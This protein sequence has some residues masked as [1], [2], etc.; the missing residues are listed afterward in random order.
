MEQVARLANI[1]TNFSIDDW[2]DFTTPV[3]A[4][5]TKEFIKLIEKI[6]DNC[7][8][9]SSCMQNPALTKEDKLAYTNAYNAKKGQLDQICDD[10]I[11]YCASMTNGGIIYENEQNY[12]N[13][14]LCLRLSEERFYQ[15]YSKIVIQEFD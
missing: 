4:I 13:K 10:F 14:L 8:M 7:I 5:T 15:K 9:L 6:N 11:I 1:F 3:K 2:S 12:F